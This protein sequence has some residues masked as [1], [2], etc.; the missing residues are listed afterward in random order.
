MVSSMERFLSRINEGLYENNEVKLSRDF[1][2]ELLEISSNDLV[3]AIDTYLDTYEKVQEFAELIVK[4]NRNK[5][6]RK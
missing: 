6:E 1:K 3:N 4:L 5:L 2:E